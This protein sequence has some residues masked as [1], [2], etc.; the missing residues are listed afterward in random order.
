MVSK[1]I[2]IVNYFV[3]SVK[4][5]INGLKSAFLFRVK[6]KNLLYEYQSRSKYWTKRS[7]HRLQNNLILIVNISKTLETQ[8]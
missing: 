1:P 2:Y 8:L 3:H 4:R 6:L 5:E 7:P